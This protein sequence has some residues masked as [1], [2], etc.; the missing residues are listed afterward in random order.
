M[1]HITIYSY[2]NIRLYLKNN[3]P[4]ISPTCDV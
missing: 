4:D 2:I 1:I 3:R